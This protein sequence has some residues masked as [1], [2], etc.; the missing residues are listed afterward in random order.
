MDETLQERI[1][2]T[3][4]ICLDELQRPPL[5]NA[6]QFLN[7]HGVTEQAGIEILKVCARL[8]KPAPDLLTLTDAAAHEGDV[9]SQPGLLE[10]ALL[11]RASLFTLKQIRELPVHDSVKYLFCKEFI[12]CAGGSTTSARYAHTAYPFFAMSKIVLL[13]RFPAGQ[14]HWEV[15]GFPRRWF[16]RIQARALPEAL[17]F[18]ALKTRALR[19]YFEWHLGGIATRLPFL[20]EREAL[21]TFYRIAATLEKQPSIRAIMG[22]SWMH[23]VETHRVS[24]HLAFLN[25]PFTESG[26]IYL[27]LGPDKPNSGFLA[28]DKRRAQL[29]ASGEYRPTSGVVI[30]SREQAISWKEAHPELEQLV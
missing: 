6:V 22:V 7:R 12:S 16:A 11:A 14:L 1:E 5:M 8:Q 9:V 28:G 25:R 10:R 4:S 2:T 29:Y 13:Q 18:F 15:S 21:K 3:R 23:S 19:P 30:C 20:L 27:D 24:P 26:G 17:S